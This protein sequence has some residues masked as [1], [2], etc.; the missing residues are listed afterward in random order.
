MRLFAA[1]MPPRD[2]LEEVIRVVD[3]A[4]LPTPEPG[5][6]NRSRLRPV[7]RRASADA[8]A[9]PVPDPSRELDRPAVESM[10]IPITNFGNLTLGDSI[11]LS[12]ALRDD[13][14]GWSRPVVAFAGGAALEFKGDESVWVKLEGDLD[15]LTTVGRGVPQVVQRLGYFVDRRQFRPWLSIGTITDETTAPYLQAVVDALDAFRGRS[16]TVE[17]VS[18]L[19]RPADAGDSDVFHVKEELAL[20]PG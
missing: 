14:A 18:L 16:W 7:L 17:S 8:P 5:P 1:I 2:V 13:V 15:A 10:Y 20:A 11:K 6:S 4:R 12:K 9:A 19:E 3:A